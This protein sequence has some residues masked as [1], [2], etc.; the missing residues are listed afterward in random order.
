MEFIAYLQD[1][2]PYL[3]G[4]CI[5][6]MFLFN[7]ITKH[8][9]QFLGLDKK[10]RWTFVLGASVLL[11]A[12]LGY[13]FDNGDTHFINPYFNAALWIAT[14]AVIGN[15]LGSNRRI[16]AWIRANPRR[17]ILLPFAIPLAWWLIQ[18]F[19]GLL[20]ALTI[21]VG[22]FWVLCKIL[23]SLEPASGF[24]PFSI[25]LRVLSHMGRFGAWVIE[26]AVSGLFRF[27][28]ARFKEKKIA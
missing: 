2:L 25:F 10:S 12:V 6:L 26:A 5:L 11:F 9:D 17:A 20:L 13:Y 4:E 3:Y 18:F 23:A 1:N 28:V 14:A 19:V 16:A 21:T 27:V 24:N 15:A 22:L 8:H 7:R